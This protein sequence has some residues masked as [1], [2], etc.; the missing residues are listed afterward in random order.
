MKIKNVEIDSFRLFDNEKVPFVN[1]QHQERCANLVAIH[2]PNGFGKTSLFDAI[3]FCVTNNI[4]R[5]K[6]VT[7]KDDIKS[8]QT[9]NEYSSFIHNKDNPSKDIGIKIEFE[10]GTTQERN[11][12]PDDEMK[13]LK[14]DPEN[15]YFNEVMLSQDWFCRFLSFTDATQRFEMFTKNFKDTEG[16]LEYYEQLKRAHNI[17][18]KRITNIKTELSQERKKLKDN[19][20]ERIVEHLDEA[21]KKLAEIGVVIE[22]KGSISDKKLDDLSLQGD[23]K[24]FE[25]NEERKVAQTIVCN[26]EKLNKGQD[27]LMDITKL[28]ETLRK[29]EILSKGINEIQERQ[30]K[31]QTLKNLI[32]TIDHLKAEITKYEKTNK[33]YEYLIDKYPAYKEFADQIS[34]IIKQREAKIKERE[35]LNTV[36][37]QK[38]HELN[39]AQEQ[40]GQQTKERD[41]WKNKKDALKEEYAKYQGILAQINQTNIDEKAENQ[42]LS[43]I[44]PKIEAQDK[45]RERLAQILL[46][47]RTGQLNVEIEDYKEDS[48]K[49]IALGRI[50]KEKTTLTDNL[51]RTI[52]EQQRYM[53]QVEALVVSAREMAV[54]LK[55]GVCPLCGQ[56]YGQVEGLLAA[57]ESNHSIS[58]SL[59]DTIKLKGETE[60]EIEKL[61]NESNEINNKIAVNITER[62]NAVLT[63]RNGLLADKKEIE[64]KLFE[65]RQKRQSAFEKLKAVY[66]AFENQTEAQVLAIYEERL[67]QAEKQLGEATKLKEMIAGQLSN[68]QEVYKAQTQTIDGLNKSLLEKQKLPAYSEYKSKLNERGEEQPRVD[69]WKQ[70]LIE[71]IKTTTEI[72]EKIASAENDKTK[73]ESEGV[74]LA[75]EV[76]LAEQKKE[77]GEE[78]N[79]LDAQYLRTVRFIYDDCK[80]KNV[81]SETISANIEQEIGNTKKFYAEKAE[82]C[83][84]KG[85]L[86]ASYMN[87]LKNAEQYIGQ[88]KIKKKIAELEKQAE[89][90]A[91]RQED[92]DT[93]ME[94]LKKYLDEFVLS[95][96]QSDLINF[97][98]NTIDPH[99]TYKKVR[100][101]CDF[102]QRKPRLLVI[103]ESVRDNGDKIVPNLYL[104]TAQINILSFCIFMAKAMFAKTDKGKAIDCIF[105][106]DPIQA[107]DDINILSMID[108]LRNV[109]FTLNK[110]VVIT[111]HDLNFFNLLQ[112]KM[113]QDKFN[114]CYLQLKERG[115]FMVVK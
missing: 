50:I 29:I 75:D 88:Q 98:Y 48:K 11:V 110:Q 68:M 109:A 78:K 52:Q 17:I 104:S 92:I 56:N 42:R 111:T 65:I 23:Q 107:L 84:N 21:L 103:M 46:I 74:S 71:N 19:V 87:L 5:L 49:I 69:V 105:V 47:L 53:G 28:G 51:G 94:N 91:K 34:E 1:P 24:I 102:N 81:D 63:V 39:S 90:N 96:F 45:E 112:K 82:A 85:K 72:K 40:Q 43:Q 79:M 6:T 58:K 4:Q 76:N 108:L 83:E 101:K 22:W 10:D 12:A 67:K 35:Q 100:F 113:P 2:A 41:G 36:L 15:E 61:K 70:K 27:G 37:Q 26:I 80:V 89:R 97:L 114:S 30:K 18:R 20:D 64:K 93:E 3:E 38:Q 115:K 57:I 54:T 66:T 73:M 60:H 7:F 16:L 99:P 25:V 14:G 86:L 106:D 32:A 62:I 31:I 59:E 13:L 95:Y 9:E 55:S 33:D 8:D 44:S 77:L